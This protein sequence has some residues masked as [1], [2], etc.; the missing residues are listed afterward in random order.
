MLLWSTQV[1]AAVF[2]V[3]LT[4]ELTEIVLF[5]GNLSHSTGTIKLGGWIGVVT[6]LVAWYTSA[7]GVANGMPGRLSLP[8][9][10]PFGAGRPVAA[11]P[12]TR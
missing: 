4:L 2:G 8:V 5:I 11:E 9:G 1:N 12:A 7:A 6:A 3:F 10:A